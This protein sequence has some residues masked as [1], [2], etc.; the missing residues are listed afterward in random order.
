MPVSGD[1][2]E[3]NTCGASLAAQA[4]CTI[5]VTFKPTSTGKRTGSLPIHDDAS[6][7]PQIVV[8]TGKGDRR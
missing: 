8:L 3:T 6:N 5:G 7:G 2:A 4:S 1:F